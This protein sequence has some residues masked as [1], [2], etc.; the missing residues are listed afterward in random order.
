MS[1]AT[2]GSIAIRVGGDI[3][4]LRVNMKRGSKE[5]IAFSTKAQ[6]SLAGFAK[7]LGAVGAGVAALSGV[8]IPALSR[9]VAMTASEIQNLSRIANAS[10]TDFQKMARGAKTVHVE[11]DKLADILKDV[12]DRVGDFIETGG[13]PMAD[14]FNK[15][16]P[17]VGVTA[18]EFQ[19]LSGPQAL[20]LYYNSLEKANLSQSQM[21]FYLEAVA[22][23]L[24]ALEP[25]L[26]N[27]GEGFRRIGDKAERYGQ[28]ISEVD[29]EKLSQSKNAFDDIGASVDSVQSSIALALNPE[30]EAF[31]DY[32]VS[33]SS[34]LSD[35]IKKLGEAKEEAKKQAAAEDEIGKIIGRKINARGRLVSIQSKEAEKINGLLLRQQELEELINKKIEG[36]GRSRA[37][38]RKAHERNLP[39][40]QEE[41]AAN[42]VI[43]DQL[44]AQS[45]AAAKVRAIREGTLAAEKEIADTLKNSSNKSDENSS[46]VETKPTLSGSDMDSLQ[47]IKSK[48]LTEQQLLREH[49]EELRVIGDD[50][51]QSRFQTEEEWRSVRAQA[52]KE[53]LDKL[54]GIQEDGTH[55]ALEALKSKYVTEQQLLAEH[56]E[57]MALIGDEW[58]RAKFDSEEQWRS[59]REQAE[60]DFNSKLKNMQQR[61]AKQRLA[62]VGSYLSAASSVLSGFLGDMD[63]KDKAQFEKNKKKNMAISTISLAGA[64]M[65]TWNNNGGY[66]WAI[67]STIA[68]GAAGLKQ[69]NTIRNQSFSGGGGGVSV[70]TPAAPA[71]APQPQPQ[72]QQEG[73]VVTMAG[74]DP[75]RWYS[76]TTLIDSLQEAIDNGA[77]LRLG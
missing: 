3:T 63:A 44:S 23:D 13:G 61:D 17:Q 43:I 48:Y 31:R 4:D 46:G 1:E 36:G 47:S 24:T 35:F 30:I 55:E 16:A 26:R 74:V 50:W 5:V 34:K 75:S 28:I 7:K 72:Q 10:V 2:V 64:L 56:R 18:R 59:V 15:I 6:R 57:E 19:K 33:A 9:S 12:G 20:Q 29:I 53:Y 41:F 27:N 42:Q 45:E 52:E 66:P 49:K 38:S 69:L 32:V 77:R 51:D 60:K 54:R 22:S 73:A 14:F 8:G 71:P 58:D 21:T 62:M 76:G 40:Y 25:L 70:S 39:L 65:Q 37:A 67:P 11:Q 68:M